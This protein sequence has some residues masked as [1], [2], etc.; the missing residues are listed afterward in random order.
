VQEKGPERQGP[1]PT[2]EKPPEPIL[3]KFRR[4]ASSTERRF[5]AQEAAVALSRQLGCTLLIG[6][7][8]MLVMAWPLQGHEMARAV[9]QQSFN[10]GVVVLQYGNI[11]CLCYLSP[12]VRRLAAAVRAGGHRGGL[13][14]LVQP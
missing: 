3:E 6:G 7:V 5:E 10:L 8:L 14:A 11:C 9:V 4:L 2:Q 12:P 1:M 13:A